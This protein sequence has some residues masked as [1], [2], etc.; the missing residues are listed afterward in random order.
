MRKV[1]VALVLV[2]ALALLALPALAGTDNEAACWGQATAVFA[3]MGEM[4]EHASEQVVPR[5]GLGNLARRLYYEEG[6]LDG[7]TLQDLAAWLVS[8]DPD[9]TIEAC[10]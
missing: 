2:A 3:Q 10:M 6:V 1:T 5:E 7:P 4:G 9:L 8:I